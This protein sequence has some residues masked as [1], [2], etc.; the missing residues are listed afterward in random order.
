MSGSFFGP[1]FLF[2]ASLSRGFFRLGCV[3][4]C[5]ENR[6]REKKEAFLTRLSE[7]ANVSRSCADNNLP[8]RTVYDW[9]DSDAGFK[10]AWD[11]ALELGLD[12]LEDEAKRR[13][14]EGTDR[15]VF[16]EGSECGTVREYSD[17]LAIFLLKAYRPDR[18]KDR[19]SVDVNL[20]HSEELEAAYARIAEEG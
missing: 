2:L 10:A 6:T 20:S 3:M 14:F 17:T 16:Y 4:E 13:A 12:A 7:T 18:F 5:T 19:Q 8:R 9:R 11:Q 1:L 15:P